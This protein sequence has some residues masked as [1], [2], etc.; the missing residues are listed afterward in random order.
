MMMGMT[1]YVAWSRGLVWI[2]ESSEIAR[3][4]CIF[5]ASPT[6]VDMRGS[7]TKMCNRVCQRQVIARALDAFCQGLHCPHRAFFEYFTQPDPGRTFRML[8]GKLLNVFTDVEMSRL[9]VGDL[10]CRRELRGE[11]SGSGQERL[12]CKR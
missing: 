4:A 9:A 11:Y 1:T 2:H 6:P 8:S 12:L 10:L 3:V 7:G 5:V